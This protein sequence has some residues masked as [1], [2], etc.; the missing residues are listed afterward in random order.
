MRFLQ[1]THDLQRVGHERGRTAKHL[2]TDAVAA[3]DVQLDAQLLGHFA[4]L[5]AQRL[6]L[7]QLAAVEARPRGVV[8]A[9]EAGKQLRRKGKARIGADRA[10]RAD[11]R[12]VEVKER[13]VGVE[14]QIGIT[15]HRRV[16]FDFFAMIPHSFAFR[17]QISPAVRIE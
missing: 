7:R 3:L 14:E 9:V 8:M 2:E 4:E 11:V 10:E 17:N 5:D 16:S 13:V 1:L 15:C 6:V 12:L